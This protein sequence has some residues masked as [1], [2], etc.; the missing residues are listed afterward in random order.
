MKRKKIAA[1]L[2]KAWRDG[3]LIRFRRARDTFAWGGFVVGLSDEWMLLHEL[4]DDWMRLNRYS[5]VRVAEIEQVK[6]DES[7]AT[8]AMEIAGE[9]AVPQP[10]ILMIDLPGLLSSADAHFPLINIQLEKKW[11]G[12]C[13]I[14]RVSKITKQAVWLREIYTKADWQAKPY[15]YGLK[16]ITM[17]QFGG[18][19]EAALWQ[20]AEQDRRLAQQRIDDHQ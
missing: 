8:R 11:P 19:Y 2:E 17:V 15:R 6:I 5:A 16:D 18:G 3:S 9:R 4:D 1:F 10:D 14:G 20:V 13:Y 12:T 7:F